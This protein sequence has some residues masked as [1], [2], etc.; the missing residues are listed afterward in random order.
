MTG[1]NPLLRTPLLAALV[2]LA[3]A[4]LPQR[5][6]AQ[7][8]P[9]DGMVVEAREAARKRDRAALAAARAAMQAGQHPL[10]PW[11]EYWDLSSRLGEAQVAEVEAF[12]ERWAGSYVEDR[13]RNDWLKELGRRRDW[14]ALAKDYPRF[15]MNDDREVSC[16]WLFT[17]HLAGKDVTDA[18]RAAWWAQRDNDDGC[19]LL[20][21]A[22]VDSK[23]FS[24]D[25]VYRKALLS[26]EAQRPGAAKTALGLLPNVASRDGAEAIDNPARY[27]KRRLLGPSHAA[28]ELRLL[29]VVRLAGSDVDAAVAEMSPNDLL[30][31]P[32]QAAWG[33]ATIGRQAA[34]KLSADAAGHYRRAL[35][36][37]PQP[38]V[39]EL[40]RHAD[41]SRTP[42]WTDETLAW[43]V[44]ATLRSAPPAQRW[45]Q[46]LRLV[47]AM[48]A[49]EQRDPAWTYWRARAL[50]A[51][52][53]EGAEGDAQ[54]AEARRQLEAIAGSLS[55]YA[56]LAAEDLGQP[57]ALPPAPAP[58]SA[59]ERQAAATHP[60]LGRAMQLVQLN[61]RD[62]A[63]REWN[64]SLRGMGDRELL[65]AAQLACDRSDWQLCINTAERTRG[66]FD[67]RLRYPMPFAEDITDAAKAAGLEPALVFGLIRQETRFMPQLKSSVGAAGLMQVMPSTARYVAKKIGLPW[68]NPALISDPATNLKLGTA[69][70]KMVL[71][72]LGG[73][74]PMAAAAYNA[75]PGRP[76]RWRE[77]PTVET[78][79]WAEN[80]PFNE[81]RDYVK[82]VMSN[83]AVYA[84]LLDD[85]QPPQ[86]RARLGASIGPREANG[87]SPNTELP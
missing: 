11:V 61:L 35:G 79:V 15:R 73:S 50:A 18:A 86:L 59:A 5:A 84:S 85:R 4:A 10:T 17:E 9:L 68:T 58:L 8:S 72:D 20:A 30:L 45:P 22:M 65:A 21:T 3:A 56:K 49:T 74:Q 12:Y 63:R 24:A 32:A 76:R 66:E 27:L 77:G 78:A 44:R 33:W 80:I 6:A 14:A 71:D 81:T 75:G 26:V 70:L 23:R 2:A 54:R 19:N 48:S 62:E 40:L 42:G 60:G 64:F 55:F 41:G 43:G 47:D 25:D 83:A 36:L 34:V 52:A 7:A 31:R 38:G 16:W 87:N 69:Y 82:K 29:A 51:T 67:T 37:L 1:L 57:A 39:R 28:Q 46:V 53:R 13:L